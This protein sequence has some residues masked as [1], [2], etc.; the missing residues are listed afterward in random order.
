MKKTIEKLRQ[1]NQAH[2]ENYVFIFVWLFMFLPKSWIIKGPGGGTGLDASCLLSVNIAFQNNLEFGTEYLNTYGPLAFLQTGFLFGISKSIF[3]LFHIFLVFVSGYIF[4]DIIF[5]KLENR[6]QKFIGF[7]VIVFLGPYY[8]YHYSLL[9]FVFFIFLL[10]K[11]VEGRNLFDIVT[12]SI[13]SVLIFYMKLNTGLILSFL[14][15]VTAI[16]QLFKRELKFNHLCITIIIN[17]SLL[18]SGA[19]LLNT[20]II[21]Y[22][23]GSK[24]IIS[25]FNYGM[26]SKPRWNVLSIGLLTLAFYLIVGLYNFRKEPISS[27]LRI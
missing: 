4:Y 25:G 5:N 24:E 1:L 17:L 19:Y 2:L 7:C 3:V 12:A 11:Y 18:I 14:L 20:S 16:Y 21:E 13:I 9:F 22:V 8:H 15:I 23:F 6:S 27:H 10:F 26:F